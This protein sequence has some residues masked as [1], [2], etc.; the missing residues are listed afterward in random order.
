MLN[1]REIQKIRNVLIVA[2]QGTTKM[3]Y[4]DV[5]IYRDGPGQVRQITLSIGFTQYGN[6]GRVLYEYVA[7]EVYLRRT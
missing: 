2:E 7:G 3:R 1:E 6:L 4:K 5:Y